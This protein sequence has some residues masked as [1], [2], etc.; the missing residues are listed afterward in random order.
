MTKAGISHDVV[1]YFMERFESAYL[2]QIQNFVDTLLR[3]GE[4]AVSGIDAVE[5]IRVSH[6]ATQSF[7][8]QRI[9]YLEAE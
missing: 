9:V 1:P 3:G 6:A 2:A 7:H 8:E 5:A 4:P